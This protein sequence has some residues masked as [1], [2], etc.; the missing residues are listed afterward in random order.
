MQPK[1]PTAN[2][3]VSVLRLHCLL[4]VASSQLPNFVYKTARVLTKVLT[5]DAARMLQL[6]PSDF[7][8]PA[9]SQ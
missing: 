7:H 5:R 1:T 4:K 9:L 8:N 2:A 6:Q 3:N